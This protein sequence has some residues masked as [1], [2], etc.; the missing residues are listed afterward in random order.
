MK[1]KSMVGA[2]AG[3]VAALAIATPATAQDDTELPSASG[4]S[5]H[6][7]V[8]VAVTGNCT[9]TITYTNAVPAELAGSWAYWGDYRA[10]DEAGQPDS[11]FPDIP[12]DSDG[13][14]VVEDY[15]DGHNHGVDPDTLITSGPLAGEAFGLQYNPVLIHQGDTRTVDV[16]VDAPATLVAWIK[17]GPEQP[18]YVGEVAVEVPCEKADDG[19]DQGDDTPPAKDEDQDDETGG[20]AGGTEDELPLTGSTTTL[21]GGGAV[22]LLGL[23]AGAYLVARRRRVSFSA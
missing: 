16:V 17:R 2:A 18:W 1:I 6:L 14:L 8:T 7:A 22:L 19:G 9:A 11:E 3:L 13:Q 23:G 15:Q 4:A 10:G 5:E 20:A 21:L 12:R